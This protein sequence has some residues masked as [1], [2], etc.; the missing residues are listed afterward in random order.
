MLTTAALIITLGLLI[1]SVGVG[2]VSRRA[3]R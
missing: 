2:A 1:A 3:M